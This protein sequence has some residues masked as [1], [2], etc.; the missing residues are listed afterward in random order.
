MYLTTEYT[1]DMHCNENSSKDIFNFIIN[2]SKNFSINYLGNNYFL[3]ELVHFESVDST[4]KYFLNDD[5][6]E[7]L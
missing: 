4:I 3:P 7:I 6:P 5:N 2:N 1:P